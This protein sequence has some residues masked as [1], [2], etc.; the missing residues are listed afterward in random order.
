MKRSSSA[1]TLVEVLISI[2][3][4]SL[5][6]MALYKS[7]DLLRHSNRHLYHHLEQINN[8]VRGSQTLYL[9]L[10]QSDGNITIETKEKDFD[11]LIISSTKHSLYGLSQ[12]MVAWLIYK[13]ENTLLRVEGSSYQLPLKENNFV[14]IDKIAQNIELFKI[15]RGKNPANF[16]IIQKIAK[17]ESQSF[18]V[19]NVSLKNYKAKLVSPGNIHPKNKEKK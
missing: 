12:A 7:S 14:E 19:H 13:K 5:V 4:L 15:Y 1:F 10:L 18:M 9:D 11:R 3:L 8:G 6:L 16:L 17:E 2:T